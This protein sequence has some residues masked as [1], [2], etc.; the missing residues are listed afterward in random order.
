MTEKS[1]ILKNPIEHIDISSF[2]S[3]PIIESMQKMSFS[4]RDLEDLQIF[5]IKCFWMINALLF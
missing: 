3:R 5:L 1:K 2:D 4:S